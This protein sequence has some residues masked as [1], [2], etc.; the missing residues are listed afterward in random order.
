MSDKLDLHLA[1]FGDTYLAY[2]VG[3]A[4]VHVVDE[5]LYEG[6]RSIR[7]QVDLE[8][9]PAEHREFVD[10]LSRFEPEVSPEPVRRITGMTL[11]ITQAC[12]MHCTYCYADDGTYG[13]PEDRRTMSEET[14][15]QAIDRLLELA[16]DARLVTVTFFGGE[17]L[18]NLDLVR[19]VVPWARSRAADRGK[20]ISFNMVTNAIDLTADTA[21]FLADENISLVISLDGDRERNDITKK[22]GASHFDTVLANLAP[23]QKKL[24]FTIRTTVS[25]ANYRHLQTILDCFDGHGW[26]IVVFEEVGAGGDDDLRLG[27]EDDRPLMEEYRAVFERLVQRTGLTHRTLVYPFTQT[28]AKI[29][30]PK[31]NYHHCSAGRWNLTVGSSGDLFPCHRMNGL[32]HL[33]VGRV[34][35]PFDWEALEPYYRADINSKRACRACWARY[36]CSGGCLRAALVA[37]DDLGKP[38]AGACR[39]IREMMEMGLYFST[40]IGKARLSA[41]LPLLF[42]SLRNSPG[43]YLKYTDWLLLEKL[44]TSWMRFL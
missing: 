18:L 32:D 19:A 40:R 28:L 3:A 33:S 37:N 7:K 31:R 21:R 1:R 41:I 23:V 4:A 27:E 2:D 12:N 8:Q 14:A 34:D 17:P 10:D 30:W 25:R 29:T 16:G 26:P 20:K 44:E 24:N 38:D 39:H 43:Y 5:A 22:Y 6:L 36:L 15:R 11:A 35:E 42:R 9:V 13:V